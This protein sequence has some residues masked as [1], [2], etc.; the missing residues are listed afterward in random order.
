MTTA[1][2]TAINQYA[3]RQ[4]RGAEY[5]DRAD[6]ESL[7]KDLTG[8]SSFKHYK[9]KTGFEFIQG[10]DHVHYGEGNKVYYTPASIRR[11]AEAVNSY[12]ERKKK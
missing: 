10:V 3:L 1:V 7:F 5:L 6:A 4:I 12:M 9:R 8:Y 11:F 2:K